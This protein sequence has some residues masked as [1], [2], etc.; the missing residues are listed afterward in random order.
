MKTFVTAAAVCALTIAAMATSAVAAG[1]APP[2]FAEAPANTKADAKGDAKGKTDKARMICKKTPVLGTRFPQKVCRPAG[3][4]EKQ[5][6]LDKQSLDDM[7]RN[8]LTT[9]STNPCQ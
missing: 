5:A 4:W 9:C 3:E 6:E 8:G 2:G 7:Q 1:N